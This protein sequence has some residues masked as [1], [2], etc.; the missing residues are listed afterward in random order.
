VWAPPVN[1]F[2]QN[3]HLSILATKTEYRGACNIRMI[4]VTGYQPAKIVGIF[5]GAAA[6]TLVQ[7]ESNAVHILE[8]LLR[9]WGFSIACRVHRLELRA[10]SLSVMPDQFRDLLAIHRRPCETQFLLE[11]LLEIENIPVLT[12]HQGDDN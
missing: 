3:V 10:S 4:D 8:N 9:R 6:T 1:L 5:S 12:K 11:R 2:A 7:K